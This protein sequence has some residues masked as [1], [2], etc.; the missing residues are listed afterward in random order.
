MP[1]WLMVSRSCRLVLARKTPFPEVYPRIGARIVQI[2]EHP[3]EQVL[4]VLGLAP[5]A[6]SC[7]AI[8]N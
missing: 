8:R 7:Y 3:P 5:F 2:R 4:R 6:P 1:L